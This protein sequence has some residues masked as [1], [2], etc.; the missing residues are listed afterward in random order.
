MS[1]VENEICVTTGY[2]SRQKGISLKALL[3]IANIFEVSVDE[4]LTGNF[5]HELEIKE[6]V[7]DL[8]SA[9]RKARQYFNEDGIMNVINPLLHE[10]EKQ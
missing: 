2:L 3:K 9:V 1:Y 5:G 7:E 6:S 8:K 10:E 4:L